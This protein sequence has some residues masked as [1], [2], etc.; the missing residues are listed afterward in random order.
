MFAVSAVLVAPFAGKFTSLFSACKHSL[1][2][3]GF[4]GR[5]LRSP[6]YFTLSSGN[7]VRGGADVAEYSRTIAASFTL[8]SS[9][10]AVYC[11][12]CGELYYCS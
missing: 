11:L 9:T 4:S 3:F 12:T 6:L 1:E 10:S 2:F 8:F 5:F 7:S